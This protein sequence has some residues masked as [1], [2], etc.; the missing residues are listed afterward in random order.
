MPTSEVRLVANITIISIHGTLGGADTCSNTPSQSTTNFNPR[1]PCRCRL[2]CGELA[3]KGAPFQ[4]TAPL[5]VPTGGKFERWK[6]HYHFNPRHPW[7]CRHEVHYS[8]DTWELFQSTAPLG[9]PTSR[10]ALVGVTRLFQ[11]TAP[12]GVPT[13]L[14]EIGAGVLVISIHGTLGGADTI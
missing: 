13:Q 2:C 9:V 11:S 10:P 6:G 8:P 5:G 4:S 3:A 14:L 7:G 1:H 12:L